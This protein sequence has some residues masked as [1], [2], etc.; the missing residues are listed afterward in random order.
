MRRRVPRD[1]GTF[2]RSR[3]SRDASRNYLAGID[4][5]G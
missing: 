1:R 3:I 5:E 2:H 4:I